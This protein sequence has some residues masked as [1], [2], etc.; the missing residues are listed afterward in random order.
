MIEAV[1]LTD[2]NEII[3]W[4]DAFRVLGI[5][6]C[7]PVFSKT[8]VPGLISLQPAGM[9]EA[10]LHFWRHKWEGIRYKGIRVDIGYGDP[11]FRD[12]YRLGFECLLRDSFALIERH[13]N[14]DVSLDLYRW[15]KRFF[16]DQYAV[17]SW[18]TWSMLFS[19][20]FEVQ[21]DLFEH[22]AE[23]VPRIRET[24]SGHFG[25]AVEA[26]DAQTLS[27]M[28]HIPLS[29]LEQRMIAL[30]V[31][32]PGDF[33]EVDLTGLVRTVMQYNHAYQVWVQLD[34][35]L[36]ALDREALLWWAYEQAT[37]LGVSAE[38]VNQPIIV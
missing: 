21:P 25:P 10:A 1:R 3:S 13:Y 32:Q 4:S 20:P 27:K 31:T 26:N 8:G 36:S 37:K 2:I 24:L 30:E 5:K 19:L 9:L 11:D 29:T 14:G 38:D 35:Y 18:F 22:A 12:N 34:R 28:E 7:E 15:V 33:P 23:V 16:V 17:Q 6:R